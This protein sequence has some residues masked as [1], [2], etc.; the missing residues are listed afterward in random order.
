MKTSPMISSTDKLSGIL[1]DLP[2]DL[3]ETDQVCELYRMLSQTLELAREV[4]RGTYRFPER[5]A[6]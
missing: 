5:M 1:N 4:H 6:E 2:R 3:P